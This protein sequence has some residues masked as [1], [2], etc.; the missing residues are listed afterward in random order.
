MKTA[1]RT[2]RATKRYRSVL[3]VGW[4]NPTRLCRELNEGV[5]RFWA[6]RTHVHMMD[7]PFST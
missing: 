1:P 4:V 6:K 2:F 3:P 7:K 5:R